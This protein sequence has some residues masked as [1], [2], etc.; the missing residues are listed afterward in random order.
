MAAHVVQERKGVGSVEV[1]KMYGVF[2]QR[3]VYP[4]REAHR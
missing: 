4:A 2:L 1:Y 3:D